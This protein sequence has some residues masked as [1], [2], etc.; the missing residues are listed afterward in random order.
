MYYPAMPYLYR[1]LL[2]VVLG[3]LLAC[4]GGACSSSADGPVADGHGAAR[5]DAGGDSDP[6]S[7]VDGLSGGDGLAG[8]EGLRDGGG[9]PPIQ[10]PADESPHSSQTEWWYYT[11]QVQSAAGRRF[12]FEAVIFQTMIGVKPV[13]VSHAAV[14]DLEA[15]AFVPAMEVSAEDQRDK[16]A[17]GFDL[18]VGAVALS[19]HAGR[20]RV[21]ASAGDYHFELDLSST[22]PVTLQYGR[23]FMYIGS[24]KPFYYYSYTNMSVSGTMRAQ[25]ETL[26][27]T[28]RAWMDH[29]WGTI[30]EKFGWDWFSVRLDD[31]SEL[32]LFLVRRDGQPGFVGGTHIAKDGR[33]EELASGDF[34]VE[35]T[36][37]WTSPHTS[38]EYPQG[39][40]LRVP[41]LALELQ[42]AP[43]RTDQEFYHSIFNSPIYWEGLCNVSGTRS[44]QSVTGHA[45][46]ELT[47]Q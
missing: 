20:D 34:E 21:V 14:T 4:F 2:V 37:S 41:R 39:W 27:V 15:D 32:M 33:T 46:V 36:G 23:G 25:G 11:G 47:A 18:V 29:Q 40:R 8:A 30:G 38:T 16:V 10:L 35:S 42:L 3:G 6:R 9:V 26:P 19:G 43:E 1:Y 45:Y 13:Y 44:G 7:G 12:G 28:G 24:D 5:A 17:E 22:K 31:E